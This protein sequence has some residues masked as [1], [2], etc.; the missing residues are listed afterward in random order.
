MRSRLFGQTR[1]LPDLAPSQSDAHPN[2]MA[3]AV[4]SRELD[5]E[6]DYPRSALQPGDCT[7]GK[8]YR[9]KFVDD[10]WDFTIPGDSPDQPVPEYHARRES[11]PFGTEWFVIGVNRWTYRDDDL[12]I[13]GDADNPAA[14][15]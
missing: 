4:A 10:D 15:P 12:V 9:V 1:Q 2:A 13:L 8:L 5:G 11:T 3:S 7:P 6:W 14:R